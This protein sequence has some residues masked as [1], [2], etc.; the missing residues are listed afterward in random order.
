MRLSDA[1]YALGLE[2]PYSD[3]DVRDAFRKFMRGVH[4]D[5]AMDT[6][7]HS[8]AYLIAR[9]KEARVLCLAEAR[10]LQDPTCMACNGTG[11]IGAGPLASKTCP[12]CKGVGKKG[13]KT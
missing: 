1:E 7:G 5:T 3:V 11:R 10:R 8:A 2:K 13:E 12:A 9:A 4:P 6:H